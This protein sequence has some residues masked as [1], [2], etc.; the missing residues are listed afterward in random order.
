M[1][2]KIIIISAIAVVLVGAII[3]AIFGLSSAFAGDKTDKKESSKSS[4]SSSVVSDESKNENESGDNVEI[5]ISETDSSAEQTTSSEDKNQ[6]TDKIGN[7]KIT[8]G[9]AEGKKG[10]IVKVPVEISNNPGFMAAM[11]NFKYDNTV[12]KYLGY[13]KGEVLTDYQFVDDKGT[14]K[15]LCLENGDVA[16]NGVLFYVKFEVLKGSAESDIEL[17]V[18]D[19]VNYNEKSIKTTAENGKITVK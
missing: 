17:T 10:S 3:G 15:F 5:D 19:V 16:T 18:D 1:K 2:K 11:F 13:E 4:G 12:V 7:A 14:L 6:S 9:T 8:V